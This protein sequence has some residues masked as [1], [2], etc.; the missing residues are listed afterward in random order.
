MV[1]VV[2]VQ[3]S[4]SE[5]QQVYLKCLLQPIDSKRVDTRDDFHKR[6]KVLEF[7]TGLTGLDAVFKNLDATAEVGL[8]DDQRGDPHADLIEARYHADNVRGG[9][10]LVGLRPR[11]IETL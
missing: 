5:R 6:I 3:K 8:R 9:G 11:H 4:K 10:F 1:M 7:H 2:V